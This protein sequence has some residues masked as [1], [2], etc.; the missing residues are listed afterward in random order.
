MK[1]NIPCIILNIFMA[2]FL[3]MPKNISDIFDKVPLRLILLFITTVINYIYIFK[4]KKFEIKGYKFL[5]LALIFLAFTIPSIFVSTNKTVSLYTFCKFLMSFLFFISVVNL[6]IDKN[7]YNKLRIVLTISSVILFVYSYFE[8]IFEINLFTVGVYHFH[9][10]KGRVATSFFNTIYYGI[11][12]NI[13]IPLFTFYLN[14]AKEK[15]VKIIY[16]LLIFMAYISLLLTFT[17]SAI[18]IFSGIIVLT[19]ILNFKT[20]INKITTPLYIGM[21]LI[22]FLIPGVKDLYNNTFS[23]VKDLLQSNLL[24]KFL[25]SKNNTVDINKDSDETILY[26]PDASLNTRIQ[27]SKIGNVIAKD[28]YK[29][30]IGFGSYGDY[31]YSNEYIKNYPDFKNYKTFPHS[32]LVLLYSEVGIFSLISFIMLILLSVLYLFIRYLKEKGIIKELLGLCLTIIAGFI[33]VNIVAENAV[34]D[35]QI[36]PFFLMIIGLLLNYELNYKKEKLCQK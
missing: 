35:S 13:I 34:Y 17:R 10:A 26:T 4:E 27:L 11:F 18:M 15:K 32:T 16:A 30:G 12:L 29:T 9:G 1:K 33:V 6:S 21:I 8:Y 3:L 5:L 20:I 24:V 25:P 31:V 23:E 2:I 14:K 36:F 19:I 7:D 28:H 22:G